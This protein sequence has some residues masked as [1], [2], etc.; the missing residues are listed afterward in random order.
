MPRT[1]VFFYQES[2]GNVPVRDWLDAEVLQRDR[3][4]F[5]KCLAAL[6]R[7]GEFGHE[8]RRPQADLLR[9]GIHELRVRSGRANYRL[10]YFHG[11]NICI[12]AHE[13]AKEAQMPKRDIE[14]ALARR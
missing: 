8:L 14:R 13:L 12:L 7:L 9:D 6:E 1:E 5:R 11:R 3:K 4:A 10:L 2:P